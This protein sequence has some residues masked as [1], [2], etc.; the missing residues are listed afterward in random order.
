MATVTI[1]LR[2]HRRFWFKPANKL[3]VAIAWLG[4]PYERLIDWLCRYGIRF[5]VDD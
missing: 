3:I 1:R 2:A 5:E 4:L